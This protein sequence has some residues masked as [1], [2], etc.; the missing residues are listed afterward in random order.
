MWFYSIITIVIILLL[1][2]NH[3]RGQLRINFNKV[4]EQTQENQIAAP[5][6]FQNL[7]KSFGEFIEFLKPKPDFNDENQE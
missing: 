5:S 1:W 2:T 6:L 3:L 7:K 4:K